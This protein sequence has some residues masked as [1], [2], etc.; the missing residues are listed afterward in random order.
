MKHRNQSRRKF[1][2]FLGKGSA[3]GAAAITFAPFLKAC[4]SG[5]VEMIEAPASYAARVVFEG[6]KPLGTDALDLAEG[7]DYH[8][9]SKF[10]DPISDKDYLGT[11]S[12]YLAFMPLDKE[13][14]EGL[15]W[16]N[17]EYVDSLF[18]GT[19]VA[20][21]AS[22]TKEAV[23]K[24]RYELGGSIMKV[25]R[26]NGN[27]SVVQND[28][29]N[30]R[31][32][33]A[34]KIPF[35]WEEPIMGSNVAEG[36]FANCSGGITPWGT[37][38]TCEENYDYMYGDSYYDE[39]GER[40]VTPSYYGWEKYYNNPPEHYGW[41]VEI[42]P[43][44]GAGH[45]LVA[46]GRCAHECAT[47]FQ[48]EDDR[49]VVYTGDDGNDRCLYKF[50]SDEPGSLE[51]GTLYVANVESG[52][53]ISLKY[54]EQTVL[55]E[56]FKDQT[57]VLIRCREAAILVGG[58]Q[59]ARPEDIEIDPVSGA[60]FV[61]LTN[62]KPKGDLHGSILKITEGS[63]DK[64]GVT[65]T[66][67]VFLAGGPET[68]FSSPDN[69]AFDPKGNLWFTTD[70]SGSILGVG[71]YAFQPSNGLYLVPRSGE[72]AG[73]IICVASAPV[74]AE[75]TGPF[76]HPDGK[77]LFLSVQH[78]G[79]TSTDMDNLTSNWPE[80][81]GAMPKSGIVAITGPSLEALLS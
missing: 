7:F 12:D 16:N 73:E 66:S 71:D 17:H 78:P 76:F 14:N 51:K 10:L 69:M 40:Q 27:W 58:S 20:E 2:E 79:E 18:S 29:M 5:G 24:E 59:L 74:A 1:I 77:T 54:E 46:L 65:F 21:G 25:R 72:K 42:D 68:G 30:R 28:P 61:S 6:I 34:T 45:K 23:D 22:K 36:T 9:I 13:G 41:V 47:M 11:H 49:V 44:T 32:T 26:S 35:L 3:M 39:A 55:Q 62:N 56:N 8:V 70:V 53:W 50:V 19:I 38:L 64:T 81:N 37:V 60:V 31:I 52:T 63:E 75:F 43:K 67:E 4:K 48:T 57:E 15:I 33:A 80:G